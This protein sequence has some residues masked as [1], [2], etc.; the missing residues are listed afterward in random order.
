MG[1]EWLLLVIYVPLELSR[2]VDFRSW[3]LIGR[4]YG[5]ADKLVADIIIMHHML[6]FHGGTKYKNH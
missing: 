4:L 3:L 2:L 6:R 5:V 1:A